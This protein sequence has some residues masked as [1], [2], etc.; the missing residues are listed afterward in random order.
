MIVILTC[1]TLRHILARVRAFVAR[2]RALLSGLKLTLYIAELPNSITQGGDGLS[3]Y[4]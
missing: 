3:D 1:Q 4:P 2:V